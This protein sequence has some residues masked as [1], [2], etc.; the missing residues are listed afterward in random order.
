MFE[1]AWEGI[2]DEGADA[3]M[4]QLLSL[5]I[6]PMGGKVLRQQMSADAAEVEVSS[7][8]SEAVL[9]RFGTSPEDL[10]AG[11][12]ITARDF[13]VIYDLQRPALEAIGLHFT[14]GPGKKGYV[15]RLDRHAH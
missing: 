7:L 3:V 11:F 10:L 1:G 15:L 4:T 6:L 13:A 8:P 2:E 14:H 5:S 9:G 12:S